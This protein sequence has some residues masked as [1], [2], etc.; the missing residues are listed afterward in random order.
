M[1]EKV[2]VTHD[3]PALESAFEDGAPAAPAM[4]W[5]LRLMELELWGHPRRQPVAGA[6]PA[7]FLVLSP[8]GR[9][10]STIGGSTAEEPADRENEAIYRGSFPGA[11]EYRFED[12]RLITRAAHGDE[13][14][15]VQARDC[16]LEGNWLEIAS[17]WLVGSR[18]SSEIRRVVFG[19]RRMR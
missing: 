5:E 9:F 3:W 18:E 16:S 4:V 10:V 12:G 1:F 11:G 6:L 14:E 15:T 7:G 13:A 2:D 8:Q 19:F 17:S